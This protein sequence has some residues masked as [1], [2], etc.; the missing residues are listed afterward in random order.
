MSYNLLDRDILEQA[1]RATGR[2]FEGDADV[3][4]LVVGGAALALTCLPLGR[5]T[6]DCDLMECEPEAAEKALVRAAEAAG[7][8]L[9]L[10]HDWLN[11]HVQWHRDS[12]PDGWRERRRLVG[13]Y[14]R[15]RIFAADRLDLIVMKLVAGRPQDLEDVAALLKAADGVFIRGCLTELSKKSSVAQE[16]PEA[17]ERLGALEP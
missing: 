2:H 10:P 4:L 17:F 15:L 6:L 13:V 9:G 3:E 16:I 11:P 14:G 8:E 1:F 7:R 5:T 12:L